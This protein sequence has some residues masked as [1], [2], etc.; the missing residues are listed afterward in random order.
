VLDQLRRWAEMGEKP[1]YA[2]PLSYGGVPYTQDP[3]N[4]GG[5]D[6]VI[7][8]TSTDELV[9]DRPGTRFA[10]RDPRGELPARSEPRD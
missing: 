8:G 1:D 3:S 2:G 9:S 6:L 7:V 4:L 5:A 10:P